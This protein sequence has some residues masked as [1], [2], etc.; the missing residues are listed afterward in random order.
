MNKRIQ[1]MKAWAK[2]H[3]DALAFAG[4]LAFYAGCAV[5]VVLIAKKEQQNQA[6]RV[7]AYN[8]ALEEESKFL[9]RVASEGKVALPSAYGGY[10]VIDPKTKEVE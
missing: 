9:A 5:G 6:E 2:E 7:K 3:D 10:W 1:K 8:E 4:I